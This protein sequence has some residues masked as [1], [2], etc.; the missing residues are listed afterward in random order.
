MFLGATIPGSPAILIGFND[1]I[2]WGITNARR[3]ARDW[4]LIDFKDKN[5]EEYGYDNLLLKSQ[6]I[7]EEIKIKGSKTFYDTVVYTHFGPC[8]L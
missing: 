4:Y 7:I 5:R 1:T 6:H 2:A 3:D 8:R